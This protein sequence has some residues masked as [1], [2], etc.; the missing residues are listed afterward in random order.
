MDNELI[1]KK[2]EHLMRLWGYSKYQLAKA[3]GISQSTLTT[4][5]TKRS[6]ISLDKLE[7]ISSAF[8]MSLSDFIKLME[9][10]PEPQDNGEFPVLVWEQLAPRDKTIVLAVMK[11]FAGMMEETEFSEERDDSDDQSGSL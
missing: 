10:Y 3:S 7:K 9:E 5:F 4:I 1:L 6:A 8:H 2:I 11:R